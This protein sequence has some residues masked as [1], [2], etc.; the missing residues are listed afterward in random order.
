MRP[1]PATRAALFVCSCSA[2]RHR[3]GG[4]MT[5]SARQRS[6]AVPLSPKLIA[7][8]PS[9]DDASATA[10]VASGPSCF[11]KQVGGGGRN[12]RATSRACASSGSYP[13]GNPLSR[14]TGCHWSCRNHPASSGTLTFRCTHSHPVLRAGQYKISMPLC[15]NCGRR[16]FPVEVR[17]KLSQKFTTTAHVATAASAVPRGRSRAASTDPSA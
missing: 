1:G 9:C 12:A 8:A 13:P 11:E 16:H 5:A 4:A 15:R 3:G 14:I 2:L 6:K 10:A 7:D 17:G